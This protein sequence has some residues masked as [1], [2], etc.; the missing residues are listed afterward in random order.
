MR[1]DDSTGSMYQLELLQVVLKG[2]LS[3][4]TFQWI[5]SIQRRY[6]INIPNK[7]EEVKLNRVPMSMYSVFLRS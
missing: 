6:L 2:S 4:K 5:G 1:L 7:I 3:L